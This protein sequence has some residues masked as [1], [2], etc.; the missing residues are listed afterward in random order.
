MKVSIWPITV[1]AL[2]ILNVSCGKSSDDESSAPAPTVATGVPATDPS[3]SF[4]PTTTS[5]T[6][7]PSG[8][9]TIAQGKVVWS[10]ISLL[11]T[12]KCLKCHAAGGKRPLDKPSLVWKDMTRDQVLVALKKAV[13][14]GGS[15]PPKT[16]PPLSAAESALIIKWVED[17][18]AE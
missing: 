11:L 3:R 13:A 9:T 4:V 17:G 6:P 12:E 18:A 1:A 15:M 8:L 16:L 2:I 10:D 14:P 5:T 7:S